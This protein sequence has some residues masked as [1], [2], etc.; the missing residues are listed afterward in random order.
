MYVY[1][2]N[3]PLFLSKLDRLKWVSLKENVVNKSVVNA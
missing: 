3:M 2:L 1:Q